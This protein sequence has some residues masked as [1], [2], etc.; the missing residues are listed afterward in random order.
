MSEA[1]NKEGRYTGRLFTNITEAE[2]ERTRQTTM[3]ATEWVDFLKT[4]E[5][6]LERV[7]SS[8]EEDAE[9]AFIPEPSSSI[10]AI[11]DSDMRAKVR[12]KY[13]DL[14]RNGAYR[15]IH[16]LMHIPGE[17]TKW[18]KLDR[19]M[20][21]KK[22]ARKYVIQEAANTHQEIEQLLNQLDDAPTLDAS[23]STPEAHTDMTAVAAEMLGLKSDDTAGVNLL[24]D[25]Y[26]YQEHN[27]VDGLKK[28]LEEAR[29]AFERRALLE[30]EQFVDTKTGLL[31]R[32]GIERHY[33]RL[34]ETDPK[35]PRSVCVIF[36]DVNRFKKLNDTL[37]HDV[38]DEALRAIGEKVRKKVRTSDAGARTSGDE[39]CIVI[40]VKDTEKTEMLSRIHNLFSE[41]ITTIDNQPVS[42]SGG[43]VFV[44]PK[45]TSFK[46]AMQEAEE[47]AYLTK[48]TAESGVTTTENQASTDSLR[49]KIQ[50]PEEFTK[51]VEQLSDRYLDREYNEALVIFEQAQK[52]GNSEAL[53]H[54]KN[55]LTSFDNPKYK[56]ILYKR[57]EAKIRLAA[58]GVGTDK[59]LIKLLKG[60]ALPEPAEKLQKNDES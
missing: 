22:T 58:L 25:F 20:V 12:T 26:K 39:F 24:Q 44:N 50:I 30:E 2:I 36:F 43:A 57:A 11:E 28:Y 48:I 32:A 56:K 8:L 49:T 16:S 15:Y 46:D 18:Q 59:I 14:A 45:Q 4:K 51:F 7:V 21:L 33:E 41:P 17:E 54:A 13:Y 23:T 1:R 40:E 6:P 55:L 42:V 29:E 52:T 35:E 19:S 27:Y 38:A 9:S 34:A 37:G 10:Q 3:S 31:N 53:R 60:S 5:F 47:A